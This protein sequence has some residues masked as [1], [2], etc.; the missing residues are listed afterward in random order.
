[1]LCALAL[2]TS[3][4]SAPP[5]LI[6]LPFTHADDVSP[7]VAETAQSIVAAALARDRS[8]TVVSTADVTRMLDLEVNRTLIGCESDSGGCATDVASALGATHVV[9]GRIERTDR[10]LVVTLSLHDSEAATTL[11]RERV[12]GRSV[13]EL[14]PRLRIGA[15]RIAGHVTGGSQPSMPP[16]VITREMSDPSALMSALVVGSI[17]GAAGALMALP[18]GIASAALLLTFFHPATMAL[19]TLPFVLTPVG[20]AASGALGSLFA[21]FVADAPIGFLRAAIAPA[22]AMALF[23]VAVPAALATA[24]TAS[25]FVSFALYGADTSPAAEEFGWRTT[26]FLSFASIPVALAAGALGASAGSLVAVG[27]FG[28]EEVV[29]EGPPSTPSPTDDRVGHP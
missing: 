7:S 23:M 12:I 10:L 14:A 24:F 1:V 4:A 17:V 9:S 5:S 28:E 6:V 11:T 15:E 8:L 29:D 18:W 19:L 2:L 16:L 3:L 25:G 20:I 22:A 13:L 21:D 27:F 26:L